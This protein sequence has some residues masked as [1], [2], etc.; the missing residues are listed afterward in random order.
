MSS[1]E[2]IG[3][4]I[5]ML[6]VVR[7]LSQGDLA[8]L[9]EVRNSSISNYERGKTIPKFE[10]I[11]KLAAGLDLPLS[12]VEEAQEFIHRMRSRSFE[13][14]GPGEGSAEAL[15]DGAAS[16]AP[17]DAAALLAEVE[18]ISADAGRVA[19]RMTRLVLELLAFH[20]LPTPAE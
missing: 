1:I 11:Q 15:M 2:D 17:R 5:H 7:G 20:A 3:V 12:A 16:F 14:G 19:S 10:S 6:R 18:Q 13:A 4:V 9:S 8:K